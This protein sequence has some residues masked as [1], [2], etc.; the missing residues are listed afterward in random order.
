[1][2]RE[3]DNLLLAK[4]PARNLTLEVDNTSEDDDDDVDIE[5]SS[6]VDVDA[7][8]ATISNAPI[9]LSQKSNENLSSSLSTSGS[10]KRKVT[11]ISDRAMCRKRLPPK[12][13]GNALNKVL[14]LILHQTKVDKD[15]RE[16]DRRTREA[17]RMEDR[18]LREEE[19][20]DEMHRRE[21]NFRRMQEENR[22][23]DERSDRH[24]QLLL[25]AMTMKHNNT[26]TNDGSKTD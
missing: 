10:M 2:P 22:H 23:R 20:R 9:D 25:T 26:N 14:T 21:D 6:A 4:I 16:E 12:S 19:W 15:N 7:A 8:L 13:E 1:M 11:D 17:E 18:R 3:T 24:F 5:C